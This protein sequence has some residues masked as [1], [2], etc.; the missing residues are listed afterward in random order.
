MSADLCG[1]RIPRKLQFGSERRVAVALQT[2]PVIHFQRLDARPVLHR[3]RQLLRHAA[4]AAD[5]RPL[6]GNSLSSRRRRR[7][8]NAAEKNACNKRRR[9][10]AATRAVFRIVA[11]ISYRCGVYSHGTSSC[12]FYSVVSA[13]LFALSSCIA[14]YICV[15]GSLAR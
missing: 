3:R 8:P 9:R 13:E 12:L 10:S 7:L 4:A 14:N 5:R 11:I 1:E 2:P 15:N 6:L